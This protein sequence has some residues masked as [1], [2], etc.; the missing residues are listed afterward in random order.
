MNEYITTPTIG[1]IITEEFLNPLNMSSH[2][3][4][5]GI[6]LS[7]QYTIELLEGNVQVT[8]ELSRRLS[9]FFGMSELFFYR[10]QQNINERNAILVDR[11]LRDTP[12]VPVS[13]PIA[14]YA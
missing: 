13:L 1:E 9:A 12:N 10:L 14:E 3:L 5:K 2:T 11:E 6:G 8:P 7:E 4:A